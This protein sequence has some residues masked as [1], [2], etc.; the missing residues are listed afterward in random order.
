MSNEINMKIQC[1][2]NYDN[3]TE[4]YLPFRLQRLFD[5]FVIFIIDVRIQF[6]QI[7]KLRQIWSVMG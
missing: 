4:F 6:K 2:S 7:P 3:D 1:R 5:M